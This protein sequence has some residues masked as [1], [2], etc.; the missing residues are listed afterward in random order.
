M[1]TPKRL[2]TKILFPFLLFMCCLFLFS[3][4]AHNNDEITTPGKPSIKLFTPEP[5]GSQADKGYYLHWKDGDA[6]TLSINLHYQNLATDEK[7]LI[8]PE[9]ID[10]ALTG[11]SGNEYF[12]KTVE[13]AE[14]KYKIWAEL[15]DENN[16][17][18]ST[19]AAPGILEIKHI[20][21]VPGQEIFVYAFVHLKNHFIMESERDGLFKMLDV[22]EKTDY[23][24]F[25]FT[26]NWPIAWYLEHGLIDDRE[27]HEGEYLFE[28]AP[29]LIE[30]LIDYADSGGS[31]GAYEPLAGWHY[32]NIWVEFPHLLEDWDTLGRKAIKYETF[33]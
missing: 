10:A 4:Q 8:N 15:T 18:V 23:N 27:G 12:W 33:F 28:P 19:S 6:K 13:L 26:F 2:E 25:E 16:Q 9:P 14:G 20:K 24:K 22:L 17:V 5:S 32:R 3:A 11:F 7:G 29:K 31:I 21:P 30:K 1:N